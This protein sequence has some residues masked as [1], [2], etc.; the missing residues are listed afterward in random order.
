MR[1]IRPHRYSVLLGLLL[2]ACGLT[3]PFASHEADED[4]PASEPSRNSCNFSELESMQLTAIYDRTGRKLPD[5][6]VNS[7]E[8]AWITLNPEDH[9]SFNGL[10]R[11]SNCSAT[12]VET[13]ASDPAAPAYV[14]TNGHCVGS[15]LLSGSEVVVNRSEVAHKVMYL[16]YYHS[17]A[18][19]GGMT[20]VAAK[21]IAFAS[22]NTTDVAIVELDTTLA[23]LK[24]RGHCAYRLS[25]ER[26]LTGIKVF[27]GGVPLTGVDQDHLGLHLVTCTLGETVSLREGDYHFSDS[28]RHRCSIV[29]GNSGS[30]VFDRAHKTIVGV[31]NTAVNDNASAQEDC[32]LDKPC[33][34]AVDGSISTEVEENYGQYVYFL[35][36][37]FT[38]AGYFDSSLASCGI[39]RKFGLHD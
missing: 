39:A 32:S 37:C 34:I 38:S 26:P 24:A 33:E 31:V 11:Y 12:L 4:P 10:G 18:A 17:L 27:I 30:A 22:M 25:G 29:G 6:S 13:N 28:F 15:H 35:A 20:S 1:I 9:P 7:G 14:L 21:T 19:Q 3:N 23:A 5:T 2:S 36:G 8:V 16:G